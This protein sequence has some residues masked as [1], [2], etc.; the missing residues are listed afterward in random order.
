MQSE[1]YYKFPTRY[2]T[3]LT[4][5]NSYAIFIKNNTNNINFYGQTKFLSKKI[6]RDDWGDVKAA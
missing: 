2:N 6:M 1:H 4:K 5:M 3:I